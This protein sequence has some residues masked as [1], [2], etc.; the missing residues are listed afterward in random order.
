MAV[1]DLEQKKIQKIEEG[2]CS[3]A[4]DSASVWDGRDRIETLKNRL[5]SSNRKG[6]N[7]TI[8]GD[9]VHW[10]NWDFAPEPTP[11]WGR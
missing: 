10:Q 2:G 8:T 9:M 11:A 7:Y 5:R 4:Y 3:G 1:V 6:K